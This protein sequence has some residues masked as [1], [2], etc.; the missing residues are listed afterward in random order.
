MLLF[1]IPGVH[2]DPLVVITIGNVVGV[3]FV[4]VGFPVISK[5]NPPLIVSTTAIVSVSFP[6][7][8]F[9]ET[10]ISKLKPV[11]DTVKVLAE[12]VL[13]EIEDEFRAVL[14]LYSKTAITSVTVLTGEAPTPT[15]AAL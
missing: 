3:V 13:T 12:V 14:I 2:V 8:S 4:E 15:S 5:N 6:S 1:T 9:N 10:A 7:T 11:E